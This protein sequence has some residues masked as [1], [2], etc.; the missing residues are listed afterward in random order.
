MH[1][2]AYFSFS[3][4]IAWLLKNMRGRRIFFFLF[5]FPIF[6]LF[7]H[8]W[9]LTKALLCVFHWHCDCCCDCCCCILEFNGDVS[10]VHPAKESLRYWIKH[11]VLFFVLFFNGSTSCLYDFFFL[12]FIYFFFKFFFF[13]YIFFVFFV[14]ICTPVYMLVIF[15]F[16][17]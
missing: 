6:F 16:F 1:L 3:F 8:S 11:S 14:L 12:C 9:P 10:S 2:E 7:K 4:F 17:I 15:F 5:F 13:C